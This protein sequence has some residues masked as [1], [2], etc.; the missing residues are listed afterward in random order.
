MILLE[1][2]PG[3]R[4]A[5]FLAPQDIVIARSADQLRPALAALDAARAR[6]KWVAGALAYEAGHALEP[7]LSAL[8]PVPQDTPLLAFGIYDAPADP[9]SL[10][11]A[12]RAEAPAARLAPLTPMVSPDAYA[13]AFAVVKDHIAAGNCYQINLTFPL[14]TELLSGTPLGLFGALRVHQPVG[15]GAYMDLGAGPV[16]VSRSPEMFFRTKASGRI[17]SRPMKGTAPRDAD[18]VED[19]ELAE[20]LRHSPKDRAE[21]LMIVD[22]LRND[23]SRLS[24]IGSVRVPELFAVESFATVHQMTSRVVGQLTDPPALTRLMPA[25]FPCGSITGAP[26]IR[27]MQIIHDVEPHPRGAYCG[28]IGWMAPDG[29]SCFNVAI[30]TLSLTGTTLTTPHI[31]LNVGGGV[32]HDSTATGEWEEALWKTRYLSSLIQRG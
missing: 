31:R 28:A 32:V 2:G 7:A 6:G 26:K 22:L 5:A 19:A 25:L 8:M 15:F 13:A 11:D 12:A 4:P 21:N 29:A 14:E 18:P 9:A 16:L 1:H 17:E 10:L 24:Q 3:G 30:R 20:A 27:A 23:I